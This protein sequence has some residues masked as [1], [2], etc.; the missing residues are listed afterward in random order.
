[1]FLSLLSGVHSDSAFE[2]V[3]FKEGSLQTSVLFIT[4]GNKLGLTPDL[5]KPIEPFEFLDVIQRVIGF[6]IISEKEPELA[7][8]NSIH[9]DMEKFNILVAE[10]NKI[11]QKLIMMRLSKLGRRVEVVDNGKALV[12]LWSTGSFD[13]ILMDIQMSKLD[14]MKATQSIREMETEIAKSINV[15]DLSSTIKSMMPLIKKNKKMGDIE[16]ENSVRKVII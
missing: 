2:K 11:N 8:K 5:T 15:S 12:K 1:M 14:G 7:T 16:C 9:Q 4:Q 13:L 3:S 10:D 6:S